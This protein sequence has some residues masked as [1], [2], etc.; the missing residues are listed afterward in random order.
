[1]A[2]GLSSMP[3]SFWKMREYFCGHEVEKCPSDITMSPTPTM[4]SPVTESRL[5]PH[6]RDVPR[7]H[8]MPPSPGIPKA[9]PVEWFS[10]KLWRLYVGDNNEW[11]VSDSE[12]SADSLK[13]PAQ[14][15]SSKWG[16]DVTSQLQHRRQRLHDRRQTNAAR[17]KC[18]SRKSAGTIK[19][20]CRAPFALFYH[21]RTCGAG[22]G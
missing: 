19:R 12:P 10:R 16:E 21:G 15:P 3:P 11:K 5:F 22:M 4:S 14:A 1:M 7:S 8:L 18:N 13:T 2:T 20:S 17:E 9:S 6:V